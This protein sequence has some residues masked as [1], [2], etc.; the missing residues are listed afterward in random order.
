MKRSKTTDEDIAALRGLLGEEPPDEGPPKL[1]LD[2]EPKLNPVQRKVYE[3]KSRY[4]LA[5]GERGTGKTIG[6]LHKLVRHL[7]MNRNANAVVMVKETGHAVDGGMWAKLSMQIFPQWVKGMGIAHSEQRW[8]PSTKKP[9]YWISNRYG[10]WSKV[11][12]LSLYVSGDVG[13]KVKGREISFLA[14][15]EAQTSD[16]I[17]YFEKV[18][19]QVGRYHG[20][21]GDEQMTVYACNPAGTSHYLHE[22]FLTRPIDEETG[23]PFDVETGKLDKNF[24]VFH[25]PIRENLKNLPDGY[26]ERV[27]EACRRNPIE[28]ARM[29]LGQWVDAPEGDALFGDSWSNE[30]HLRGDSAKNNGLMPI[31]GHPIIISYDLGSAHSS[32]HFEQLVVTRENKFCIVFDELNRVGQYVRYDILAGQIIERLRYWDKICE[33]T[34]QHIHISD[35]SAFNQYRAATG[36]FDAMDIENASKAYVEKHKLDARFII[37]M[38]PCPKPAH[39]VEARVRLITDHLLTNTMIVSAMCPKTKDMFL[40]LREDCGNRLHPLRSKHLHSFDSL[41]YG[42]FYF[43][44]GKAMSLGK[45]EQIIPQ[46]YKIS[47]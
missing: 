42:I 43:A 31:K 40:G 41:S 44:T 19:Q 9:F 15:D 37:R 35:S 30:I 26:W 27:E 17:D 46:F 38:K 10:G 13:S 28:H 7:V 6:V 8:D 1:N 22:V 18:T 21:P 11:S 24:G 47:T 45:V 29:I 2:W 20:V 25:V 16:S 23:H 32:I 36:S 14:F 39:S 34:F 5:Y 12:L 4:I 33:A 3:C